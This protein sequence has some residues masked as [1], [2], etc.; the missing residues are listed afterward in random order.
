MTLLETMMALLRQR[1]NVPVTYGR[2][3]D[4]SGTQVIVTHDETSESVSMAEVGFDVDIYGPGPDPTEIERLRQLIVPALH[5]RYIGSTD[6]YGAARVFLRD[7]AWVDDD[8]DW[9]HWTM[10]FAVRVYRTDLAANLEN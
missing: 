10:R 5:Y 1:A 9:I 2:A 3:P 4:A 8:D 6:E 7:Q